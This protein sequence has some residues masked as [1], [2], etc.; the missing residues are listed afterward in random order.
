MS[1]LGAGLYTGENQTLCIFDKLITQEER[2][3]KSVIL[4]RYTFLNDVGFG[5]S[6]DYVGV[7]E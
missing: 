7:P 6:K 2:V 3:K 1:Q 5:F 4:Y